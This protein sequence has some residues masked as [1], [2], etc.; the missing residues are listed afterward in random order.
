MW[1]HVDGVGWGEKL[2]RRRVWSAV[3]LRCSWAAFLGRWSQVQ[4]DKAGG[5]L[6]RGQRCALGGLAEQ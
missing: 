4:G 6:G 5:E 2:R 3:E 1:G